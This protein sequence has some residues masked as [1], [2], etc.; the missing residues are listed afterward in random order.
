MTQELIVINA[1]ARQVQTDLAYQQFREDFDSFEEARLSKNTRNTYRKLWNN[2]VDYCE[3][4]N[5]EPMPAQP[6]TVWLYLRERIKEGKKR[7]TIVT[8]VAMLKRYHLDKGLPS[9]FAGDTSDSQKLNK[10]LEGMTRKLAGQKLE[11]AGALPDGG[12]SELIACIDLSTPIGLRDAAMF[13]LAQQNACRRSEPVGLRIEDIT[14]K[15]DRAEILLRKS[16]TDQK[17]KGYWLV[18]SNTN[19]PVNPYQSLKEWVDYLESQ[20][21][22]KGALFR[23]VVFSQEQY[24]VTNTGDYERDHLK[25]DWYNKRIKYYAKKAGIAVVDG[26]FSAHSLRVTF[27]ERM[28]KAGHSTLTIANGGRWKSH[29]TVLRYTRDNIEERA[30]TQVTALE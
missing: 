9:P 21:I 13:T 20:G 29:E 27:V 1:E 4:N 17:G 16:K 3:A 26:K 22:T 23:R 7:S 2:F 24:R 11:R 19:K 28:R 5:L 14:W 25:A 18:A 15:A 6:A 8:T 12:F 10:Q 30:Q